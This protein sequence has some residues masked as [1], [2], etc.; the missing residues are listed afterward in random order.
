MDYKEQLN[1]EI[2][3]L[4]SVLRKLTLYPPSNHPILDDEEPLYEIDIKNA[5]DLRTLKY[6]HDRKVI[7]IDSPGIIGYSLNLKYPLVVM[8]KQCRIFDEY[9]SNYEKLGLNTKQV[10]K[11][12]EVSVVKKSNKI[13]IITPDDRICIH[14]FKP[15][16][17]SEKMFEYIITHVDEVIDV[18]NIEFETS[19]YK[20]SRNLGDDVRALGFNKNLKKI[21]FPTCSA[22]KV[23]FQ[24]PVIIGSTQLKELQIGLKTEL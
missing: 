5:D 13:Y 23:V 18:K 20:K 8:W 9:Y 19:G 24:N 2:W 17:L 22:N 15:N 12:V 10:N 6:L 4:L 11:R 1:R 7:E 16:S 3:S 21:F 14:N